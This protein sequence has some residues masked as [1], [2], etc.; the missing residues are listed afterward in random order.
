MGKCILINILQPKKTKKGGGID[1]LPAE[2]AADEK[3]PPH[4]FLVKPPIE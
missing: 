4:Q 1:P 2:K 3:L